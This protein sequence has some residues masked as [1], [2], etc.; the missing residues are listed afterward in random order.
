M[1]VT[2]R[3]HRHPFYES[4]VMKSF[5]VAIIASALV[6]VLFLYSGLRSGLY[7]LA[8]LN[9]SVADASLALIAFVLLIGPLS[10]IYDFF[11]HSFRLWLTF[12]AIEYLAEVL[13]NTSCEAVLALSAY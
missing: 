5:G 6:G 8:I 3:R 13:Y 10:R 1:G 4:D 11:D 9:K 2:G 12:P 7:N